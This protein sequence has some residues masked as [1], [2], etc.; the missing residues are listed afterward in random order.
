MKAIF[1]TIYEVI[2][3]VTFVLLA[4]FIIRYFLIQP[5]VVEGQSM[6]PNF[7]NNEYLVVEKVSSHFAQYKRGDV[8]VFKS[9]TNPDLDYIKRIIAVPGETIKITNNKIYINGTQ[10]DEDY[11]PSG[12]LTLIDQDNKMILE[13]TLGPNEY[14]VL[15]DNREH[16]SDSREFGVLDKSSIVGKVWITVYPWNNFGI[17]AHPQY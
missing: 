9:P 13:K 11:I 7:H 12:D 4:A 14:F 1:S 16:S 17:I 3:T 2:K 5:F 8:V 10:I 6:E 15:G